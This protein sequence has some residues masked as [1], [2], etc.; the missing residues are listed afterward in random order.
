MDEEVKL[1]DTD[2]VVTMSNATYKGE[3]GPQGPQGE[4]GLSAYLVAVDNGFI[5][6]QQEWL[7]TLVGETGP[8]GPQG[9]SAYEVAVKN[10]FD[11]TELEWL[12][13]L[14]YAGQQ[15]EQGVAG[16]DGK[17]AYEVAVDNGFEGT[18][19][20]WLDTLKGADGAPGH[21]GAD[22]S[23]GVDGKSAY[24]LAVENGFVGTVSQWLASLNGADGQDG[25]PGQNGQDGAPGQNG[26]D[27]KSAY[28]LAVDNGFVGNVSQWLASL[29]GADGATGADGQ[30]GAPGQSA[31]EIAISYGFSG[32]E[33]EWLASLQGADGQDGQDG[34]TPV[35]GV[36]YF[37]SADIASIVAQVPAA[38]FSDAV[39][40][41]PTNTVLSSSIISKLGEISTALA[42][43]EPVPYLVF[44]N[45]Q[46]VIHYARS[47]QLSNYLPEMVVYKYNNDCFFE[48]K[49]NVNN[50]T[51]EISYIGGSYVNLDIS[52]TKLFIP[53]ASSPTNADTYLNNFSKDIVLQSNLTSALAS[54]QDSLV[55]N[56]AYNASSNKVATMS[57][58][59]AAINNLTSFSF[60]IVQ[61]LPVS[62]ISTSKIYLVLKPTSGTNQVYTEYIYANNA[63]EILGDTQI[64]VSAL[65]NDEVQA[66]WDTASADS[67]EL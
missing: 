52:N 49:P 29:Q 5:G 53:A 37:T 19:L 66:I 12:A 47:S 33:Q 26:S 27:G 38:S 51:G 13:S 11:G 8:R 67:G 39:L 60:E 41:I 15:G 4:P 65:S 62:N 36:D 56:T 32:T 54:K 48:Y 40:R 3:V 63:W 22:G 18:E 64:T 34:T 59:S 43:N 45:N 23:D 24:E 44:V 28:E 21:D 2:I 10:G 57:D 1:L 16:S 30:D 31:Y 35:K 14:S 7:A 25:T 58:I 20:E 17:S 46:L 50:S 9:D 42:N 6:S 61:S 55:F